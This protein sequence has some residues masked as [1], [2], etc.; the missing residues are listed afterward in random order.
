MQLSCSDTCQIWMW[1]KESNGYFGK[2]ENLAYGEF[3]EWILSNPTP[4]I[5]HICNQAYQNHHF[6][7]CCV[8]WYKNSIGLSTVTQYYI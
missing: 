6:F 2:I 5:L 8:V 7:W 3:K 4:D 1:C